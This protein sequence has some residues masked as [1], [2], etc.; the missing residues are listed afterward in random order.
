MHFEWKYLKTE[1]KNCKIW[2]HKT[3]IN[4]SKK[5]GTYITL[6]ARLCST[7]NAPISLLG[8]ARCVV[9]GA[10]KLCER[11]RTLSSRYD[12]NMVVNFRLKHSITRDVC[13]GV[14]LSGVVLCS[15][16]LL[17]CIAE[18]LIMF[19]ANRD[20]PWLRAGYG[21]MDGWFSG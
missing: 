2:N 3:N 6:E 15:S 16:L 11:S 20:A 19:V 13:D 5:H 1:L 18:K 17:V 8:G 12:R 4:N 7:R 9:A 14:R 21:W 10:H